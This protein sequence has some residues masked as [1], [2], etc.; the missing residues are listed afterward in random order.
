VSRGPTLALAVALM[1]LGGL[2]TPSVATAFDGWTT[3]PAPLPTTPLLEAVGTFGDT[4]LVVAGAGAAVAV[5]NDG[6][7]KW[8]DISA[9][10]LTSATLSGVAFTDA[11]HGVVVGR[12]GTILVGAPDKLGAFAWNAAT[13]PADVTGDLRDVALSGTVGYAVGVGG[14]I[15]KTADGGATWTH[16]SAPTTADLN[17]VA[18]SADG[19]VA[20]AV[21][22]QGTL[23][24][25]QTGSWEA[26]DTG[27]TAELI[28]VALPAAATAGTVY[29]CSGVQVWSYQGTGPLTLLPALPLPIDGSISALVLVES[30]AA[31]RLVAG[32]RDGWMAGIATGGTAWEM[33][34]GAA[35]SNVTAL[36]AA[37]NGVCY[38]T[39]TGGAVFGGRVERGLNAGWTYG[40]PLTAT[41]ADSSS[42]FAA[43]VTI[44]QSVSLSGSTTIPAPGVMLL[45]ARAATATKWR[46]V[47]SGALGATSLNVSRTPVVTSVYRLRFLFAGR[48]AA[49]GQEIRVGVRNK[50]KVSS[51][52]ISLS[53]G[54]VYRVSGSVSPAKSG[55]VVE[56][57]TDR[58]GNHK[59]GSWHR[60]SQG[61]YVD[62]VKGTTFTTRS[63]GT[64]VRETY[65]LKILMRADTGHLNGWSPV[66]TVTVR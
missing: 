1:V 31:S 37:G 32:G 53:L 65:H 59:L 48:T 5:S 7:V 19:S 20:A 38:A 14:V 23:L 41:P 42:G 22:A 17:A 26:R 54:K 45:E 40:L 29:C 62:L 4:G 15:L 13:R 21:G 47:S 61:G 64:P 51:A 9:R 49:T 11:Q 43:V 6:G 56:V 10:G 8:T 3:L 30:G 2:L 55:G 33:Q 50:V 35:L 52:S 24:V 28:D 25:N 36:S 27:T 34:T 57:W 58:A 60:I 16:E 63:F 18:V 12:S 46:T 44:G 66:I 39:I